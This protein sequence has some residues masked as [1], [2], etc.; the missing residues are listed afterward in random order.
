MYKKEMMITNNDNDKVIES[1][2]VI[3]HI[4]IWLTKQI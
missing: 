4:L 3:M 2:T 1:I